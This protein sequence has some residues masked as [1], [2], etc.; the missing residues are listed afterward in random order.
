MVVFIA[1]PLQLNQQWPVGYSGVRKDP[2]GV[3]GVG[4]PYGSFAF[5][6][7]TL[8]R[9]SARLLR[10]GGM[11]LYFRAMGNTFIFLVSKVEVFKVNGRVKEC[12][13]VKQ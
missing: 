3:S 10:S 8:L 11:N 1:S 6:S 9:V 2:S 13:E 5:A 4:V 7:L 12:R